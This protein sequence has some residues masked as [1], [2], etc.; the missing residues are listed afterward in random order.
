M[1]HRARKRVMIGQSYGV[2]VLNGT[3][4]APFTLQSAVAVSK[5]Y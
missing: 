5:A 2:Y 1:G 3:S 4:H